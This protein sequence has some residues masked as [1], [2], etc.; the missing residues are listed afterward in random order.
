MK[1]Y[2][3]IIAAFLT[4]GI[5]GCK[6]NYLDL[7]TNP[8]TPSVTTPGLTL[9]AALNSTAAII[10]NDYPQYGVWDGYWTTSGNYV[11]NQSINQYQFTNTSFSGDWTDWYLN[12]TNYNILQGISAKSGATNYQAI[13]MIMK[14]YGFQAL[15]DQYNDVPYT[16]AFQGTAVLL[17]VYDKGPAIYADLFKQIDAAIALIDKGGSTSTP[18]SD[19]IVFGGDM[20]KWRKFANTLKLRMAIRVS[21]K[22]GAGTVPVTGFSPQA[23]L[24]TTVTAADV[25]GTESNFLGEKIEAGA[26]PG[27]SDVSG[28]QNPYYGNYGY[29]PTG[30]VAGGGVYYRANA[31]CVGVLKSF[32][33]TLR[34]PLYYTQVPTSATD[35]TLRVH[36]NVFGDVSINNLTNSF[37]S[38]TGPGLAN[39]A[40]QNAIL[41]SGAESLFLQAEAVTDGYLTG[42]AQSLYEGG[43]TAA[44]EALGLTAAQAAT[45]YGQNVNNVSWAASSNK[46][47]AII[48]QKWISLNGYFNFEAWNE[49]R[50]TNYPA[51]PTSIDPA[52]IKSHLPTRLP[53]PL[54]ELETNPG[55]LAKEGAIDPFSSVI[56]WDLQTTIN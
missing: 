49:F 6:K 8:N 21:G 51:L 27:Y 34:A 31:Y 55:N 53:Y 15:V 9:S 14:A 56:F 52:A 30:N 33:D 28:K 26:N 25:A 18:G 38:T 43:I 16:Q 20:T 47:S 24:A 32:S 45:Y 17:P 2:I 29:D 22:G 41:L 11:P 48:I 46:E 40:S 10:V 23:L 36:G 7:E 4:A 39:S 3:L 35:P 37:N 13:A 5:S 50:R 1:K 44:F 12:L 42:D 54:V 19:D